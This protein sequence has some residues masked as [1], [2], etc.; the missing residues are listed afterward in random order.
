MTLKLTL[1]STGFSISDLADII[2][3]IAVDATVTSATSTGFTGVGTYDGSPAT[4]AITGTGF[5]LGTIGGVTY[6]VSGEIDTITF[7]SS[8]G[9]VTFDQVGGDPIDMSVFA[10]IIHA[11]DTGSDPLAIE[12]YLLAKDWIL[13]LGDAD[14]IAPKGTVI[15]DGAKLNLAGDDVIYGGKGND[16]LFSGSGDDFIYGEHGNDRLDGGGRGD[17]LDGGRGK[18]VLLGGNGNDYLYGGSG[19]DKIY[20]QKG[21]DSLHGDGSNDRLVGGGGVDWLDGGTGDDRM[22]GGTGF[23]TF[24]FGDNYGNDVIT[25]FDALDNNEKISLVNVSEITGYKD[26]TNNHMTQVGADVVIDDGAGTTITLLNVD[27]GDLNK[28]DFLF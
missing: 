24:A 2:D 25:D 4:F 11:D 17:V 5:T 21:N 14:D 26:L 27:I 1:P 28:A 16:D 8:V 12:N 18:D 23:D 7:T 22:T 15:G 9:V 10:P 3:F 20:G 19:N 13:T 6:V